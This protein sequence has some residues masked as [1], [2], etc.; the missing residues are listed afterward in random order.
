MSDTRITLRVNEVELEEIDDYIAR[1]PEFHNRSEFIRQVVMEH[2]RDGNRHDSMMPVTNAIDTQ[3]LD[4]LQEYVDYGY[5]RDMWDLVLYVF[6]RLLDEGKLQEL[7]K[8]HVR[9][10]RSLYMDEDLRVHNHVAK[11]KR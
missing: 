4:V 10:I 6:R 9:N 3:L 11:L 5:F 1:H 2:I 7:V 8:G